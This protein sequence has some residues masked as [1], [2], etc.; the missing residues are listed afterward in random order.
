[1]QHQPIWLPIIDPVA[2]LDQG[3]AIIRS[4]FGQFVDDPTLR[5]GAIEDGAPLFTINLMSTLIAHID[6]MRC[7][8]LAA[9]GIHGAI[10]S[11]LGCTAPHP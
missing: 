7:A 4:D 1:M 6:P 11:E 10:M 3:H 9:I 2:R 5:A 8:A